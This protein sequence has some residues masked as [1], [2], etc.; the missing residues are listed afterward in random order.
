MAACDPTFTPDEVNVAPELAAQ[1]ALLQAAA[2]LEQAAHAGDVNAM[3]CALV[4]GSDRVHWALADLALVGDEDQLDA[5]QCLSATI[6][7]LVRVGGLP[8]GTDLPTFQLQLLPLQSQILEVATIPRQQWAAAENQANDSAGI[9]LLTIFGL[10]ATVLA[11]QAFIDYKQ[12]RGGYPRG[13]KG[14]AHPVV[15]YR[16]PRH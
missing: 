8:D 2:Y 13:S 4:S 10:A 15:V 7:E 6:D 9:A 5:A 3:F 16:Y 12:T 1:N 14:V 11:G